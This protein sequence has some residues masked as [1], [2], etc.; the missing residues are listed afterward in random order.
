MGP[1]LESHL[2]FFFVMGVPGI[3]H[4]SYAFQ[5]GTLLIVHLLSS[6]NEYFWG[7]THAT[8]RLSMT[9]DA[10]S[11]LDLGLLIHH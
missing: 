2:A 9:E 6:K 3:E 8:L 5:A 11:P 1:A 7:R 10:L 4:M